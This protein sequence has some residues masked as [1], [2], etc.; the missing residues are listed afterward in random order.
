M[1]A[2]T[3]SNSRFDR[4]HL[5]SWLSETSVLA[6]GWFMM[7]T[8]V[9]CLASSRA[10]AAESSA[11]EQPFGLDHV[12]AMAE[13]LAN[14]PHQP[15]AKV[16]QEFLNLDYNSY[17]LISP[18]NENALWRDE[19]KSTWAEFFPAG[20]LFPHGVQIYAVEQG[21]PKKIKYGPHWFQF[22]GKA[23]SL[24]NHADGEFAGLRLLAQ[25]PGNKHK[26]EFISFLG[27]SYF[28]GIG[29]GQWYGASARGLAIDIGLPRPEEFPRFTHL[30]IEEPKDHADCQQ[31]VWA[32]LESP[33]VVGAYEFCIQ[34]GEQTF[35]GVEARL[36]RR[37]GIQKL[38]LAPLTSMFMWNSE[39]MPE[40]AIRPEVH[41][42][43]E[44]LI[45]HGNG[46]WISR[47]LTRP[48]TP[49]V[50]RWRVDSLHG[51]G[52]AQRERRPEA[53]NDD[54]AKY[55]LRPNVWV[56]TGIRSH[57]GPGW[58]ELLELPAE[59]EGVDNIGAYFVIDQE[60]NSL[61]QGFA[62]QY[63]VMFGTDMPDLYRRSPL[64]QTVRS[65][66]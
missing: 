48:T 66:R 56:D 25:L 26:T 13:K 7:A 16:P 44:L 14:Q 52:L 10:A 47:P 42:S 45:H 30:W 64:V 63:E 38:A 24:K 15:P 62:I 36:W 3:K 57:W 65:S 11:V 4:V 8:I 50:E 39:T 29:S 28:R 22:R 61:S 33:G 35:V 5:A 2:R 41:D 37:H 51:F 19:E 27:A 1:F 23:K 32:L 6:A 49:Q 58:V 9:S 55:H 40:G 54:E 46:E 43:D 20:F 60:A 53:Y 31:T 21:K 34:P 59:H 18:R 17:R 12:C